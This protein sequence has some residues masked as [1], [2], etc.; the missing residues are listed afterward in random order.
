MAKLDALSTVPAIGYIKKISNFKQ[1][2]CKNEHVPQPIS[3]TSAVCIRFSSHVFI[4]KTDL[5]KRVQKKQ[6]GALGEWG[7]KAKV[8]LNQLLAKLFVQ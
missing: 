7:R 6:T 5:G 8:L 4:G 1:L 3:K 2:L